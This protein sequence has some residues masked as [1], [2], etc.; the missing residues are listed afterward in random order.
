[1]SF[2]S[3][4]TDPCISCSQSSFEHIDLSVIKLVQL[5]ALLDLSIKLPVIAYIGKREGVGV[6]LRYFVS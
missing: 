6:S 4:V 2:I 5:F 3:Q 1:M